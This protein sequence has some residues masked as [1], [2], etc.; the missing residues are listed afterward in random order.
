MPPKLA[1]LAKPGCW[2]E[3]AKAFDA[4]MQGQCAQSA[5][6]REAVANVFSVIRNCSV[7]RGISTPSQPNIASTLW[8]TVADQKNRVYYF[9]NTASPSLL[10]VRLA[11]IDFSQGSGTRTLTMVG[12][13]DLGG[14]QTASFKKA[15]PFKFLTPDHK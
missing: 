9:E 8:R 1:D 11:D 15:Q 10:W 6:P 7:P 5:D 2:H 14:N 3:G 13:P 4:H 12:N